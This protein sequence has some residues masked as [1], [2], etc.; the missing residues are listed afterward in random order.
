MDS[1]AGNTT[2]LRPYCV[3]LDGLEQVTR[4]CLGKSLGVVVFGR[5]V[6]Q[7]GKKLSFMFCTVYATSP[8]AWF[9]FIFRG[10]EM[11]VECSKS[12]WKSIKQSKYDKTM[13]PIFF[14][15]ARLNCRCCCCTAAG[16]SSFSAESRL[17]SEHLKYN[18]SIACLKNMD[19]PEFLR[20]Q[21]QGHCGLEIRFIYLLKM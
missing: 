3:L 17:C 5:L 18:C 16:E 7:F 21:L 14:F 20:S 11:V 12:T 10:S 9:F 15:Q 4:S 2:G 8:I 1:S 13:N 6:R 19:F